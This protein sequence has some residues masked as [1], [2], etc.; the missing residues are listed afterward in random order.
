MSECVSV[1]VGLCVSPARKDM[2]DVSI[3]TLL[4]KKG[5]RVSELGERE[6]DRESGR[7]FSLLPISTI[8][9]RQI[10]GWGRK[11]EGGN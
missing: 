9:A 4:C 6:G 1:S 7:G 8:T 3:L 5:S 10:V 11:G 2:V